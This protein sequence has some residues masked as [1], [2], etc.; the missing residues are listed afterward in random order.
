[1]TYLV[2]KTSGLTRYRK[3]ARNPD[4]FPEPTRY[5]RSDEDAFKKTLLRLFGFD[6]RTAPK[7]TQQSQ[8]NEQQSTYEEAEDFED[9]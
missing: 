8:A 4:Q 5:Y 9:D 1:M 7:P 2:E 6:G 3:T